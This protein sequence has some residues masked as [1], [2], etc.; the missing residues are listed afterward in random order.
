MALINQQ[1]S[2]QQNFT[3]SLPTISDKEFQLFQA[4]IFKEAGIELAPVK[5]PLLI[6]RLAHRLRNLQL[7]SFNDYYNYLVKDNSGEM[8]QMLD[9]ICTNET[10]FFREP[11]HF[12]F[13][14]DEVFPVLEAEAQRGFR[15]RQIRVW[16]AACSTG[17]EPYSLA[18]MLLDRFPPGSGWKIEIVATDLSTKVLKQAHEGIWPLDKSSEIP[19]PYLKKFMLKGGGNQEGKMKASDQLRK[20]ITFQRMNLCKDNYPVQ[21]KFDLIFCR[22]V[23]IYFNNQTKTQVVDRLITYLQPT[24]FFLIGHSE[25]LIGLTN[26]VR[27]FAPTIYVHESDPR[28]KSLAQRP[29]EGNYGK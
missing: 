7:S 27:L 28:G 23:M 17:E 8:V 22:N 29:K 16:S 4:L 10:H 9:S 15:N 11:Q 18:M 13:L 12:A 14:E 6:G 2:N 19:M 21:G 3:F 25:S 24:G 1:N 5:K 20:L 26:S